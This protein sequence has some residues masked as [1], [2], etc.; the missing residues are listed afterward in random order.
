MD[1]CYHQ[2]VTTVGGSIHAFRLETSAAFG[3]SGHASQLVF[4]RDGLIGLVNLVL[5]LFG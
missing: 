2:T 3:E 1:F 4:P 5:E